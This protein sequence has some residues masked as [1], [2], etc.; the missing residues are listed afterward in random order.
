MLASQVGS[1]EDWD[2]RD[3]PVGLFKVG[4]S[5]TEIVGFTRSKS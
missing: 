1:E 5:N 4:Y 3:G 2:E